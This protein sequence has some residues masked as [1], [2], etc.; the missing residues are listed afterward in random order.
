[1]QAC[2]GHARSQNLNDGHMLRALL[3]SKPKRQNSFMKGKGRNCKNCVVKVEPDLRRSIL[4]CGRSI[5]LCYIL[6]EAFWLLFHIQSLPKMWLRT[7]YEVTRGVGPLLV[8]IRR[9]LSGAV[10]TFVLCW[11]GGSLGK[12]RAC[13]AVHFS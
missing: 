8:L 1:M 4:H 13:Q 2:I 10:N 6:C 5:C 11:C 7:G 12:L 9:W 3:N